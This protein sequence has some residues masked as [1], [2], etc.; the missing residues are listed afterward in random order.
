M[1]E[2]VIIA[3]FFPP[4][5]TGQ[6]IATERLA[7][8]LERTKNVIRVNLRT[9]EEHLRLNNRGRYLK[10]VMQYRQAG[11]RLAQ[12]LSRHPR[13]Q[14]IWTA[15][16]PEV[17]GHYRDL[18]TIAPT[19]QATNKVYGVVHWGRFSKLFNTAATSF[20]ARRLLNRLEALVFL[21]NDR[22]A[23]CAP[24]VPADKCAV[25]PNTLDEAVLCAPDEIELKRTDR[26]SHRPLSV[27]YLSHMIE[28]KGYLDLVEALHL[29]NQNG[30]KV[31]ATFAGQ[32][33]SAADQAAFEKKIS[34]Y[35]LTEI[36]THVGAV[37]DRGAVKKLH[38]ESDIF[39][40]PS[41]MIEGQPLAIIEAMNAGSPVITTNLGGMTNMLDDGKEGFL[42]DPR[43]PEAIG[44][45]I[46]E[47]QD[48]ARWLAQS[49]ASRERY[50][51]DYRA[52]IVAAQWL[53]LL[54]QSSR[55]AQ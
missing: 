25:I 13:S 39:V 44:K 45:R 48:P 1:D 50:E 4:P 16:S 55:K 11:K 12:V 18:L 35:E 15:I 6:G 34:D 40:L 5:V 24:W 26:T 28:E 22:A 46:C 31:K 52:E 20:T 43:D 51:K 2:P 23:Q 3:G 10:K 54:Q 21:N 17:A 19:F 41:Y 49:I 32:W 27:L 9:E 33:M 36:I 42:V 29:A 14:V 8:L 7:S 30:C 37:H 53:D 38:L 47:L